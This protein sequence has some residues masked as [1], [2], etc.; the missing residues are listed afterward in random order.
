M[1]WLYQTAGCNVSKMREEQRAEKGINP[2]TARKVLITHLVRPLHDFPV[3]IPVPLLISV[4]V[5]AGGAES[6][7]TRTANQA[8]RDS[9]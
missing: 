8:E 1:T 7:V 2:K 5:A 4:T 3:H 9:R 6:T